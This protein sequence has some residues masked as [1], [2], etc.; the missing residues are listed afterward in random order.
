M[1]AFTLNAP[2]RVV[3]ASK[4]RTPAPALVSEPTPPMA[5]AKVTSLPLVSMVPVLVDAT[6]RPLE[7]S[8]VL[9]VANFSVELPVK[10]RPV[11]VPKVLVPAISRV[12][13]ASLKP[14]VKALVA[15]SVSVPLPV[16]AKLPA[17]LSAAAK[18]TLFAPI[19]MVPVLPA[20]ET[21][22]RETSVVTPAAYF[23]VASPVKV[24]DE[25]T[26]KTAPLI[27]PASDAGL[28]MV[29]VPAAIFTLPA[30]NGSRPS[31]INSPAPFLVRT[32][33]P[34]TAE[35]QV[36]L[37]A[38]VSTVRAGMALAPRRLETSVVTPGP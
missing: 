36:T 11:E 9:P 12:P 18:V 29:K 24:S 28:A 35:P 37:L 26:P 34:Y 5:L 17:P 13:W 20:A 4:V 3:G 27:T 31:R 6:V 14:P 21:K 8:S 19:S 22:E 23:K 1:P 2:V 7:T 38:P 10:V 33:V 25:G 30:P 32:K 15:A 16:L